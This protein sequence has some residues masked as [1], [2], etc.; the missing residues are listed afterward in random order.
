M[1]KLLKRFKWIEWLQLAVS[2]AFISSQVWLDLKLPD[3]MSEVTRLVQ[4]PG[5]EIR[6]IWVTGGYKF[7]VYQCSQLSCI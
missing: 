2:I 6:E 7:T 4:T 1:F 5:S 3:Y